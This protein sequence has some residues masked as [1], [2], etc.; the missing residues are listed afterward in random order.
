MEH[1]TVEQ[2]SDFARNIVSPEAA[3]EMQQHLRNGCNR[4]EQLFKTMKKVAGLAAQEASYEPPSESV[5]IAK[6]L[7]GSAAAGVAKAPAR[8][9]MQLVLDTFSQPAL[10][11]ARVALASSRQLLYRKEDCS[12][13]IRLEHAAGSK[14]AILVGQVLQSGQQGRGVGSILVELMSGE[15]VIAGTATT[16]HG[17]FQFLFPPADHLQLCVVISSQNCFWI[18]IPPLETIPESGL[19]VN[20]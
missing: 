19:V 3:G 14:E 13:D 8:D 15:K 2:W 18:K 17:E 5:H 9:F 4:C 7:P 1:F 12:I 6:A 20:D 11:G 16:S 10:A